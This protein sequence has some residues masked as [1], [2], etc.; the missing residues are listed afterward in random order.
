[1]NI[2]E[3]EQTGGISQYGERWR[4]RTKGKAKEE[5]KEKKAK[6]ARR[7]KPGK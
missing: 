1:L 2:N 4:R 7:K 6:K 5:A 3:K